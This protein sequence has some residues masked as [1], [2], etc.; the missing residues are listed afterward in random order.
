M[1]ML[2]SAYSDNGDG[3]SARFERLNA[4][5]D[6]LPDTLFELDGQ[7]RIVEFRQGRR[8]FPVGERVLGRHYAD[9]L[10][11]PACRQLEDA[12]IRSR[13]DSKDCSFQLKVEVD[14]TSRW[15][16]L[17]VSAVSASG[18]EAPAFVIW[19]REIS[20]R[21]TQKQELEEQ[22]TQ[23]RTLLAAMADGMILHS[24][25]G[26]VATC[27]DSAAR[28]LGLTRDEL[29]DRTLAEL[30]CTFLAEDGTG[31]TADEHPSMLSLGNGQAFRDVVLGVDLA[32]G[33]RRWISANAQP[34]FHAG[35]TTPYAVVA[36]F[37]DNTARMTAEHARRQSE[38]R[39]SLALKGGSMGMW[40][41]DLESRSFEFNDRA[42]KMLGFQPGEEA[43][44][45]MAIAAMVHPD[46][47]EPVRSQ[48][49]GHLKGRMKNFDAEFRLRHQ[50][51]G[52]MWVKA[53][54]MVTSR[55]DER[56]LRACGTL[57]DISEWKALEAKLRVMATTDS[58]TGL[59]NRRYTLERLASAINPE[60]R[61]PG[62]TSFILF[63]IDHFKSVNDTLGH[64]VGDRVLKAL[65]DQVGARVRSQDTF[66]RWGGEEFAI[67][68]GNA[69]LA[70]AVGLAEDLRGLVRELPVPGLDRVT[71]SFGV[72][73]CRK[74][75][76]VDSM[77][78][79]VDKLL[80]QAK[81]EGR[82]RVCS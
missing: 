59:Y 69:R 33:V 3:D 18:S 23:L 76:S 79:R 35:E 73:E 25:S 13:E 48:M 42:V 39:L 82:D 47:R 51:G 58:L 50:A 10:P 20:H 30:P 66:A 49:V 70:E 19:A 55:R 67:V 11:E 61:E 2:A 77:L 74:K 46:D 62:S 15:F 37:S 9:L 65:A 8:P 71:A 41:L 22:Q 17:S 56:A 40:D 4:A 45:L 14:D 5:M 44:S 54:G 16:E 60:G 68:V 53:T 26:R 1:I 12:L 24:I 43:S 57:M 32:S 27:N 63:D 78:A 81:R 64:N 36:T 38:Q 75:E 34:L 31:I 28:I 52:F 21:I 29:V 80:Y 6:C 7:G 72:V